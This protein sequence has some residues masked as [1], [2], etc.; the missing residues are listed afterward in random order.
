MTGQK[1]QKLLNP[2][3]D[4]PILLLESCLSDLNVWFSE[5]KFVC[6]LLKSNFV[7]FS[8]RSRNSSANFSIKSGTSVLHPVANV[9]NLGVIWDKHISLKSHVNK[10]CKAA[11]LSLYRIGALR[12]YL[13]KLTLERLVHAFISCRLDYCNA[14]SLAYQHESYIDYKVFKIQQPV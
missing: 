4:E 9:L 3:I 5:N 10:I 14:L 11:S 7:Y 6:N 8:P 1:F 2:D 13:D 12:G